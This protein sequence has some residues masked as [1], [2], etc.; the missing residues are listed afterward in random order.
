MGKVISGTANL[1]TGARET[2]R[3]DQGASQSAQE[4]AAQSQAKYGTYGVDSSLGQVNIVQ[5]PD[6]T[7]SRQFVDSAADTI[8]NQLIQQGLG[9]LSFDPT[10]AQDAYYSQATRLLNPQ[11]EQQTENLE[12]SLA[13][14]GIMP[15]T[16][17][18]ERMTENLRNQQ[19]GQLSDISNQAI[20]AGQDL[21]GSQISNIGGLAGQ[22]DIGLL[23][24]LGGGTGAQFSSTYDP[25]YQ[26][27]VQGIYDQNQRNQQFMQGAGQA[28]MMLLSDERLKENLKPVAKLENGLTVYI[29]NYKEETG[30]DT[31]PQLFLIA[32]EVQKVNPDAVGEKDG[33][34]AVDYKE[35]VK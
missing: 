25:Y 22:R 33:Y 26:S 34:L 29:G 16:E 20:F 17:Q 32:Q 28:G 4:R 5:N 10:Q 15:G 11:F 7:Y 12:Q 21:L 31:R 19:S 14:R 13:D 1:L 23:S 6:G 27:K 2:P 8:R 18:Y 24:G 35:A 9:G 30:L 3:Y